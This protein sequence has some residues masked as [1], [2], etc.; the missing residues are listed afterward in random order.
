MFSNISIRHD[1]AL[2]EEPSSE[3]PVTCNQPDSITW[4]EK[5]QE[6]REWCR[7]RS[8]PCDFASFQNSM[9]QDE[10]A[11]NER[12]GGQTLYTEVQKIN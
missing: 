3:I 7:F 5:L 8:L 4:N 12:V 11:A 2:R 10:G 6:S 9:R 1:Q